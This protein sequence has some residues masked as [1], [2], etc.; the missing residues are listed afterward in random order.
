MMGSIKYPSQILFNLT[1]LEEEKKTNLI[2]GLGSNHG[3]SCSRTKLRYMGIGMLHG[4]ALAQWKQ[5]MTTHHS[6]V[7]QEYHPITMGQAGFLCFY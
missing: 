1:D 2:K 6:L 3:R 7:H 5:I 4:A